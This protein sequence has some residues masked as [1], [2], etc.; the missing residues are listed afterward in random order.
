MN[1]NKLKRVLVTGADGFIGSHLCGV[2]KK[3]GYEVFD[4]EGA[5]IRDPEAVLSVL[6]KCKPDGVFHL[7]A[8]INS[9]NNNGFFDV[10]S[11]GTL[12]LLEACKIAGVRNFIYSSTM[13]VYGKP[14]YLPVDEKH[15]V[16]PETFYGLSKRIGERLVEFYSKNYNLN[17]VILRYSGVYGPGKKQGAVPNFIANALQGKP[18]EILEDI[19]WDIVHVSDVAKA[20]A[21][22]LEEAQGL[23]FEIINIGSGKEIGIKEL[24][25]KIIGISK[26]KSKIIIPEQSL[27]P[28]HFYFNITKAEKLLNFN[29]ILDDTALASDIAQARLN[30]KQ[31]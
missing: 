21:S 22:A 19:N 16:Y 2:L 3:K 28:P 20:N 10:N 6:K 27:P 12:N 25:K 1:S 9:E 29:P 11:R 30:S 14:Q 26:S 4:L 8:I 23:K 18:L 31:A 17:A 5:D 15:P 24:A 7:A 13:M